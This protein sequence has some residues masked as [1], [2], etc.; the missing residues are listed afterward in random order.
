MKSH[1]L[2]AHRQ[3]SPLQAYLWTHPN[4]FRPANRLSSSLSPSVPYGT[5]FP[6]HSILRLRSHWYPSA[7]PAYQ[8]I[9]SVS[10]NNSRIRETQMGIDGEK[11]HCEGRENFF[12]RSGNEPSGSRGVRRVFYPDF[13][14]F[15][16]G[17]CYETPILWGV[18]IARCKR[19]C[20]L[21]N[22]E[23]VILTNVYTERLKLTLRVVWSSMSR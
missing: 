4:R 21:I 18:R 12:F 11:I 8:L 6:R 20:C 5:E 19:A 10:T 2:H 15:W 1:P 3:E 14:S 9:Y 7:Y 17:R 16:S 13:F 23:S 22:C